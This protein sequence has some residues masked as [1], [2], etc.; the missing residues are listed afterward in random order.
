MPSRRRIT[1]TTFSQYA[2]PRARA[3][4]CRGQAIRPTASVLVAALIAVGLEDADQADII[5]I[6]WR[7]FCDL[8]DSEL[9]AK[10]VQRRLEQMSL[11]KRPKLVLAAVVVLEGL[12]FLWWLHYPKKPSLPR[13][14]V[15]FPSGTIREG[16]SRLP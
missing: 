10:D 6:R 12:G 7:T 16:P 2:D 15:P 9:P 4:D 1:Q 13:K 3:T 11:R 14:P 5:E 8:I